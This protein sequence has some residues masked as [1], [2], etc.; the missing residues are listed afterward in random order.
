MKD[1]LVTNCSIIHVLRR[2]AHA[3]QIW[4][5]ALFGILAMATD[6]D[7]FQ[8][9]RR[10]GRHVCRSKSHKQAQTAK[11]EPPLSSLKMDDILARVQ[12]YRYSRVMQTPNII[13][14]SLLYLINITLNTESCWRNNNSII[15]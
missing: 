12:D 2:I 11:Q 4:H 1:Q 3:G 15:K 5:C 14:L 7:G 13:D 6:D 9:V 10:R 8:V